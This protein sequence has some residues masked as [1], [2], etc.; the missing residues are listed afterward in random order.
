[1]SFLSPFRS[2]ILVQRGGGFLSLFLN[3]AIVPLI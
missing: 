2:V 1:M 3:G